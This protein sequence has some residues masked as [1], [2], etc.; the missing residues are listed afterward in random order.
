MSAES[1]I[2]HALVASIREGNCVAFVGAGFAQPAVPKWD[3]LLLR[4]IGR[5]GDEGRGVASWLERKG[6]THRDYETI[7]GLVADAL[8]LGD[9]E[10]AREVR[11]VFEESGSPEGRERVDRRVALLSEIP[12]HFVLTTNYDSSLSSSLTPSAQTF[13]Q[14]LTL[15]AR[16]WTQAPVWKQ[17]AGATSL[18][19]DRVFKL[20]GDLDHPEDNPIVL[21]S[22][23]YRIRTHAL[24]GYR[25][26][27]RT[28]FATKTILYLGF[29]FT[30][31]YVNELRSEVL[32]I[33]GL[34]SARAGRDFAVLPDVAEEARG[35][36]ERHEGLSILSYD[37]SSDPEHRGFDALLEALRDETSPSRTLEKLV[38]GR[39]ILWFD[40]KPE[41]NTYGARKLSELNGVTR[42]VTTLDDAFAALATNEPYDLV[43]THFG[44]KGGE[45]SNAQQLLEHIRGG[46]ILVPVIVFASGAGRAENRPKV[47]RLGAFAYEDEWG[48][49]FERIEDLFSDGA[50]GWAPSTAS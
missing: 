8:K 25:P 28:L 42:Q 2:P 37:T 18:A 43:L 11:A 46:G 5:L 47:L 22:R 30:D 21:A 12:F 31:A 36:F 24:P 3:D 1:K 20:H 19:Q 48:A 14:L 39:R 41:N 40:P 9:A 50:G 44:Y 10:L 7:A 38:A 4:L 15:P 27:L 34:D 16:R 17:A 49:L 35:Y 32:S 29:S 6:K 23:G 33:L 13:G 45:R 26:F